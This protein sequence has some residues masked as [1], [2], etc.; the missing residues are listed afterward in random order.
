M[1]KYCRTYNKLNGELTPKTSQG[2][3]LCCPKMDDTD[4]ISDL[5]QKLDQAQKSEVPTIL[6]GLR[7]QKKDFE[8]FASW[9]E[10][11]YTRN[12]VHRTEK[13]E[14]ILLCWAANCVT[15]IHDHGGQD[16]WV[17]Q[18]EGE[19]TERRFEKNEEGE[20]V[21]TRKMT[22]KPQGL[23]YM[24]DKMGYHQLC[25]ENNER[26]YTL[27]LYASPID[28]CD[29]FNEETNTFETKEMCYDTCPEELVGV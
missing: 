13:Y 16:C 27:H 29:V 2:L 26:G 24:E 14:L 18:I 9:C 20:L 8:N 10:G 22:L 3:Y 23:T 7:L 11:D 21:E 25:N 1:L 15:P 28:E 5:I 6:K 17:Y 4:S 12:C 19:L